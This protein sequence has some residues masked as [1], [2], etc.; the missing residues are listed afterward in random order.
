MSDPFHIAARAM[1]LGRRVCV[2]CGTRYQLSP[3]TTGEIEC[4]D[5]CRARR[6]RLIERLSDRFHLIPKDIV[7]K[8]KQ[9]PS[10]LQR[11]SDCGKEFQPSIRGLPL[12]S[13]CEECHGR[14]VNLVD[15]LADETYK[16]SRLKSKSKSR[17]SSRKL[18]FAACVVSLLVCTVWIAARPA[19]KYYHQWREK[20]HFARAMA[21]FNN[22]DYRHAVLD[23][24]NT[25][26]FNRENIEAVRVMA[27]SLEALRSP[28]AVEW[29]ARLNQ[30]LPGDVENSL[31]WAADAIRNEDFPAAG[32][33]LRG[34]PY[35]DH[36]TALYHHLS[37]LVAMSRRDAAKAEFHWGEAAKLNPDEDMFKL[38][39]ASARLRLGSSA[40]RTNAIQMLEQLR[41]K[42]SERT[43]ALRILLSD[44]LRHGENARALETA[45]ILAEDKDAAFSDKL[46]RLSTLKTLQDTGFEIARSRLIAEALDRP[47][48]AYELIIW[49]NRQGYAKEVPQLLPKIRDEFLTRPPV[50]IAV[51]DSYAVAQNWP[52]L[53]K[54]LKGSQWNHLEYVRLATLAWALEK[55]GD[56]SG[57]T[58]AWKNAISLAEGRKDRLE[59]LAR[60]ATT[61]G[62]DARAQ[63]ALWSIATRSLQ[64][65]TWVL[66]NLWVRF[67]K[68]RETDKLRQIA[69][70]MLNA[71]PKSVSARNNFIFL[72]LLKRTE[73]GSP[74]QA[75]E[76]LY[77]ENPVNPSVISTYALSLY[78][79]GRA[80]SAAEIME[81]MTP[82]Q[83]REPSNAIYYGI[84]LA[85][86]NRMTKA[87]EFLKLGS[88]WPLLPEEEAMLSRVLPKNPAATPSRAG[89]EKG[90][91][92]VQ[93]A[94]GTP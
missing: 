20:K 42:S 71:N 21:Y 72:S 80:K 13:C 23:A 39:I 69:R 34:I 43:P 15:H 10:N 14:R 56:R 27:K 77:K 59:T 22:G 66:Q 67:L 76:A 91:K 30:L 4:C 90:G 25:L 29:R 88:R 12:D 51:A 93:S 8:P 84:F 1:R 24:S 16:G 65:P 9:E 32:R 2:D 53:Q 75:A 41:V 92:S 74:Y 46:L 86:A 87:E 7:P 18:W 94:T 38:N 33:I 54:A 50:A 35:A 19:K 55:S 40:E 47:E 81:T 79:L 49:M 78:Q 83:L 44:A 48:L 68:Q 26:I 5:S 6:A 64:S 62:W 70:L 11:C 73:E 45:N 63:E 3:D 57:S 58:E 31:A 28:Q 36:N 37:A 61:W 89:S 17:R 60:A 85:G 52:D 82:Q